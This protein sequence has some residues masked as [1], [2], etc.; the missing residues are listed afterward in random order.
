M[1]LYRIAHS[2]QLRGEARVNTSKNA[3]LPILAAAL[4]TRDEV[5]IDALPSISDVETMLELLK[6]CGAS[7]TRQGSAAIVRAE[8]LKSPQDARALRKMRASILLLGALLSR[9][10]EATLLTPGGCAIGQRPIDIHLKGMQALGAEAHQE[11]GEAR[12]RGKLRG[13]SVYLDFPSVGATENVLMAAVLAPGVTR[14]ENA[15]KEPEIADLA[16]FLVKMGARVAGAGTGT[17]T[18]EGVDRLHG[19]T[20]T[21]IPDRVEAGTLACAA[22]LTEGSVLLAG[23]NAQHMRAAL[24]KLQESG[25]IIQEDARGLRV[26]GRARHPIEVRTLSYPGFPTDLQAPMMV[27]ACRVPG[28]SVILETIFENRFMHAVALSQM[29]ARIRVEGQ[30]ALIHGGAPLSG[31]E[32]AAT[33]LRAAAALMLAGLIAQGETRL[34]DRQEHLLRGYE[35]L[36]DK[37]RAL[38]ADITREAEQA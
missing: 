1:S 32:V 7:V 25:V 16:N 38:G 18:V 12:L 33:D 30:L 26:R 36:D 8:S 5:V 15:A 19:A 10:G 13:G 3:V 34:V 37:L 23:A 4:L 2:P 27:V 6:D 21:P 28:L 29:G 35:G 24:Y 9:N 17:I 11:A 14:I 20:H 31:A 22:A